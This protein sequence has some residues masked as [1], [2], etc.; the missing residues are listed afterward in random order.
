MKK[1]GL[2]TLVQLLGMLGVI[3]S[4]AFVGLEMRQSQRIALLSQ[5]QERSYS[6][7]AEVYAFIETGLDWFS[8]KFSIPPTSELTIEK[9]AARNSENVN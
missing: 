8:S 7:S 5:I 9:I 4:L 2:D 1:V 6:V 3:A